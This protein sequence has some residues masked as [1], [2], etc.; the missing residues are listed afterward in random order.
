MTLFEFLQ[1]EGALY[2][3]EGRNRLN[4]AASSAARSEAYFPE[5]MRRYHAAARALADAGRHLFDTHKPKSADEMARLGE[6]LSHHSLLLHLEIESFY[7]FSKILLDRVARLTHWW[8]TDARE[9]RGISVRKHGFMVKNLATLMERLQLAAPA[10][11]VALAKTLDTRINDY[12]D[13][14]VAHDERHGFSSTKYNLD[15]TRAMIVKIATSGGLAHQ[16]ESL[17]ELNRLRVRYV[18]AVVELLT[19]NRDKGKLASLRRSSS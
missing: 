16:S 19:R 9:A 13:K 6:T 5:I 2:T 11:I 15:G 4:A 3:D 17:D 1:T 18:D 8:F 12:R 14:A 7:L 10:G